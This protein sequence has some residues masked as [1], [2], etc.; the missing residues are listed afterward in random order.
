MVNCPD[1]N[2]SMTQH[3]LTYVHKQN[4]IAKELFENLK[5]TNNNKQYATAK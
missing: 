3:T 1:C 5:Q 4:D 2:L